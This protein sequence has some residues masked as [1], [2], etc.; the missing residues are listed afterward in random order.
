MTEQSTRSDAR[1]RPAPAL[2]RKRHVGAAGVAAGLAAAAIAVGYAFQGSLT[3]LPSGTTIAGVN[4][5]GLSTTDAVALLDRKSAAVATVPMT[6]TAR[7]RSW[8]ITPEQLGVSV[9]WQAAVERAKSRAGGVAIL[10]GFHRI[11]LRFSP[12]HLR[13]PAESYEPAVD[14]EVG[15]IAAAV[16]KPHRDPRLVRRGLSIK[17]IPGEGGAVLDR[18]AAAATIVGALAGFTRG[19]VALPVRS[20]PATLIDDKLVRTQ[21]LAE[22]ILS[23][24]VTLR[25]GRRRIVVTPNQLAPMLQLPA[26]AGGNIVLGGDAG[27]AFFAKLAHEIGS[28]ARDAGFVVSGGTVKLVPA[29]QGIGLDVAKSAEALLAAAE[30][31]TNRVVRLAVGRVS[32]AR[33]TAQAKAMG[34]SGVVGT[35]ETTFGGVPNRIHNVELVAHLVDNKL[36]EPGATFSFNDTTGERTAAKGFL[37]APVIINGEVQT[38]LGGGVCQVSTTVFNAAYDAGLPITARTN[39]AIYISHYPLG[40]DATVDYP[41]TDLKFVNDTGH[42]LL[43]RTIVTSSSLVVTLYGTPQH[44]KVET[45]TT[46]LRWVAPPPVKRTIDRTLRPGEKVVDD[47]GVPA[48]TTSVTR[49]VYDASGKQLSQGTWVSNYRAVPKLVRVGPK[50]KKKAGAATTTVA[51]TTTTQQ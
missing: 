17:E 4:V 46:P 33:T 27:D 45:Q 13:A 12:L 44:R 32:P 24:P 26:N 50:K 19:Q 25:L 31:G 7:E 3:T 36:I 51:A 40:R 37:E 10:R 34:I 30:R 48:Q 35:Y 6:F 29:R 42:W 2:A 9:D 14:Y 21:L 43:L 39:H 22:R 28:T 11:Q 18:P 5:G 16:D 15:L 1:A 8:R 41:S 20:D 47:P 49:T 23:G 38:G